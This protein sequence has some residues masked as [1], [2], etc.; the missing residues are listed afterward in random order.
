MSAVT[1][2]KKLKMHSILLIFGSGYVHNRLN[3]VPPTVS[4]RN[5]GFIFDSHL[6]FS[7][8]VSS[9][10]RAVFY[11]TREFRRIRPVLDFDTVRTIYTSFVYSI[12][13]YCN[14]MYYCFPKSQLSHH[15]HTQN[16][17]ARVVVSFRSS[18]PDHILGSLLCPLGQERIKYKV[19][20]T[21]LHIS[22]STLPARSHHSPTFS[23]HSIMV[24]LLQPPV[25]SNFKV[26][27]RSFRHAAL[28][29]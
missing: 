1:I 7:H 15:Q 8:Q 10:S 17:L 14:S 4:A 16:A 21:T 29:L 23:I 12:L 27:N 26:T 6:T 22:S 5:L 28:Q 18:N 13:D 9:V 3:S 11:H 20:S 24:T 25:N 19:I 2:P